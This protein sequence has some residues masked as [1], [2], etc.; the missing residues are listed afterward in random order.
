MLSASSTAFLCA[1]SKLTTGPPFLAPSLLP[2][3]PLADE[4]DDDVDGTPPKLVPRPGLVLEVAALVVVLNDDELTVRD[5]APFGAEIGADR[6]A[7]GAGEAA[8]D[9]GCE[10]SGVVP[11]EPN[12]MRLAA[13]IKAF[14]L[15]AVALSQVPK[16]SASGC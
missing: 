9:P 3:F 15:G 8:R 11:V 12:D 1:S 14:A 13:G 7:A 10:L 4:D 5:C 6:T 2:S 16:K